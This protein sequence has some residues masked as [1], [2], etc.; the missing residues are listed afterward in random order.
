MIALYF[1]CLQLRPRA[2]PWKRVS[3]II[4]GPFRKSSACL[5]TEPPV[6]SKSSWRSLAKTLIALFVIV[7]VSSFIMLT[8][9]E[10]YYSSRRPHAPQPNA[11][12]TVRLPWTHPVS[13]G[14][15][16]EATLMHRIF[17]VGF[18]SW[19][20]FGVGWAIRIYILGED[21]PIRGE[22]KRPGRLTRE[23]RDDSN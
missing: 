5:M 3:R 6:N 19:T 23:S 8:F 21:V 9:L 10:V 14:S 22:A 15:A 2:S 13:Y 17:D 12:Q 20:L 7:F 1:R 11:G 18:Y 4:D 16:N